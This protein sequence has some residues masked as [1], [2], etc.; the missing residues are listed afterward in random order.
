MMQEHHLV[1]DNSKKNNN[2]YLICHWKETVE[3]KGLKALPY[4]DFF[5]AFSGKQAGALIATLIPKQK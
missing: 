4:A 1:T 3:T 5:D 2:N